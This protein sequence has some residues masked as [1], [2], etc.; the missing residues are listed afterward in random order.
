MATGTCHN[1]RV[2]HEQTESCMGFKPSVELDSDHVDR[3]Q[4]REL[5]AKWQAAAEPLTFHGAEYDGAEEEASDRMAE[6]LRECASELLAAISR[7]QHCGHDSCA[8]RRT[9]VYA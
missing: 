8:Q 1:V 6:V 4:L 3:D 7:E 9:C 5:A 2:N